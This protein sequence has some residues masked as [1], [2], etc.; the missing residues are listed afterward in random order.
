VSE[1][2]G[3]MQPYPIEH[4][5]VGDSETDNGIDKDWFHIC[6]YITK[7]LV[8]IQNIT[9]VDLDLETERQNT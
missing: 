7:R 5:Y 8:D 2:I 6:T 9:V 4:K 3:L 1:P